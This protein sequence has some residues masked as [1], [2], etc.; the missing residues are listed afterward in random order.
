M[1][2]SQIDRLVKAFAIAFSIVSLFA[3]ASYAQSGLS[4]DSHVDFSQLKLSDAEAL[5][6]L[7]NRELQAAKRALEAA[8][9]G[10]PGAGARPNPTLSLNMTNI[11][12]SQGVGS[13]AL[14][15]ATEFAFAKGAIGVMDLL[16]G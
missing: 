9:A 6:H 15:D 2:V 5:L 14:A 3:N 16:A 11:I 12:P 13:G 10:T 1:T 4:D 8:Q 7:H